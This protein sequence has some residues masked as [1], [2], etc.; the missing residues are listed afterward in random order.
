MQSVTAY[1]KAMI[2]IEPIFASSAV[3]ND[4]NNT[5]LIIILKMEKTPRL[6]SI[7]K[8]RAEPTENEELSELDVLDFDEEDDC[9]PASSTTPKHESDWEVEARMQDLIDG[10]YGSLSKDEK[11]DSGFGRYHKCAELIDYLLNNALKVFSRDAL[12]SFSKQHLPTIGDCILREIE[13][14]NPHKNLRFDL[15]IDNTRFKYDDH[16]MR[17]PEEMDCYDPRKLGKAY[18][19]LLDAFLFLFTKHYP[20]IEERKLAIHRAIK[21]PSVIDYLENVY[22][23]KSKAESSFSL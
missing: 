4:R 9:I 19:E 20:D 15:D 5:N 18:T 17:D 10:N 21:S 12:V 3:A 8:K 11:R 23:K 22:M 13:K 16:E 2:Y 14:M 7:R 6:F 1:R